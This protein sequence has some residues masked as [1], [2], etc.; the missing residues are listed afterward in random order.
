VISSL[1]LQSLDG[2][3]PLRIATNAALHA[4]NSIVPCGLSTVPLT[5][6]QSRTGQSSVGLDNG[7]CD[8][9]FNNTPVALI[10]SAKRVNTVSQVAVTS[11]GAR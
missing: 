8:L 10:R 6:Q 2:S 5:E 1:P 3:T 9:D 11:A 7:L 4:A